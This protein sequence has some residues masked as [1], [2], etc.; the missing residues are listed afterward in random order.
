MISINSST[1]QTPC[2]KIKAHCLQARQKPHG[3]PLIQIIANHLT[4]R[5]LW[6]HTLNI[7]YV[8][9]LLKLGLSPPHGPSKTCYL[10][11]Y[12]V[13]HAS[14]A[15]NAIQVVQEQR[16]AE[17][18]RLS[19]TG[20]MPWRTVKLGSLVLLAAWTVGLAWASGPGWRVGAE[21]ISSNGRNSA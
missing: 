17:R 14:T 8:F 5:K 16:R 21:G 20:R 10:L 1:Y 2:A 3:I 15:Q 4:S 19:T 7:I 6:S 9:V 12:A 11:C 13:V 18:S